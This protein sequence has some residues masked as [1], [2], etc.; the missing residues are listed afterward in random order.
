MTNNDRN[1]WKIATGFLAILCSILL[2]VGGYS[3]VSATSDIRQNAA[4]IR[5]NKTLVLSL[6]KRVATMEM[7]LPYLKDKVDEINRKLDEVLKYAKP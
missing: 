1:P 6:E 7:T 3:H 2:A 4:D 5:A